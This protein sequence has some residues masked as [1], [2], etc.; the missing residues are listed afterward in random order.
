[1]LKVTKNHSKYH[2]R[3]HGRSDY[4]II[5]GHDEVLD[6]IAVNN[7]VKGQKKVTTYDFSTLYT[8]IPHN[9]LK[10]NITKFV[11]RVFE[12]KEKQFI[13]PNCKNKRA[14]FSDSNDKS[15]SGFTKDSLINCLFYLIDN[16]YVVHNN[17]VYRQVIGIPMGT[18]TGPHVANVYLHI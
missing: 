10:N 14:F 11:E 15:R 1:M 9:Q 17:I 4:Y 8:S 16:S 3:F 12:I 7:L 18:N 13:V 2:N 5:D 6:Y